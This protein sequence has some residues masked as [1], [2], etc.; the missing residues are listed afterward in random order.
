MGCG[1]EYGKYIATLGGAA[2]A[3]SQAWTGVGAIA[4]AAMVYNVADSLDTYMTCKEKEED[5]A[6]AA[7][8]GQ[9]VEKLNQE[10][11]RLQQ[12]NIDAGKKK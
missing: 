6:V 11:Q 4:C 2:A 3:C 7:A 9:M 1:K 10:F 5:A 12:K 8:I